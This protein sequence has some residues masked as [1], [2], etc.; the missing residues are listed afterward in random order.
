MISLGLDDLR[1]NSDRN[2]VRKIFF[3]IF[4][5]NLKK[6]LEVKIIKSLT[7]EDFRVHR[8]HLHDHR[9]KMIPLKI[10]LKIL[11]SPS[12]KTTMNLQMNLMTSFRPYRLLK[13]C[14]R[15]A[16]PLH[17]RH[18]MPAH[19]TQLKISS[20]KSFKW[21]LRSRCVSLKNRRST[22]FCKNGARRDKC[23]FVLSVKRKSLFG[24]FPKP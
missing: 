10:Q 18:T 3:I 24:F 9:L 4:L 15:K 14:S 2:T 5:H 16:S 23:R 20:C 12:L 19:W 17:D 8:H 11:H 21:T 6:L 13:G 22:K 1:L 7:Q